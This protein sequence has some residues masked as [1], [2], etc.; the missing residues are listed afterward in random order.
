[1]TDRLTPLADAFLEV[2]DVDPDVTL[3][4]G[5]LAVF[6]GPPPT[7]EEL[8][9][10]IAGRLPLIPRYRQKL[11][12]VPLGLAAPTWV[13]D[14]DFDLT[15]HLVEATVAPPGGKAEVATLVNDLMATRM[16]RDRPLWEYTLVQGI[17][18]G[19]WGLLSKV[20]HC[21]VDGVSGTELYQL[22]LDLTPEPGP[23]VPDTWE[24]APPEPTWRFTTT[25]AR[26]MVASPLHAAAAVTRAAR[27]PVRLARTTY[28]ALTGLLPMTAALRPVHTTSLHGPV[29]PGRRWTW[30][31]VAMDDVQ[32]VRH[33]HGVSVNDVALAALSAGFRTLLDTRGEAPD[34]RALRALV[35]VSTRRPGEESI[36]DNRVTLLMPF[37]PVDVADPVER[38]GVVHER[39]AG[40]RAW[41]EPEAGEGIT[42]VAGVSPFPSVHWG[43]QIGWR[44][45]QHM[46]STVA[47]NV[48]GP[49]VPLYALGREMLEVIPYV[50]IANR[51][52][53][54]TAIFS[55]H[56]RLAFGLTGDRAT[57]L[58]LDVL[59]DGIVEGVRELVA[60]VPQTTR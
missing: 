4:I 55:Y 15:H 32:A 10:A 5:S 33:A 50:P 30:T 26:E 39:V 35:P 1:M 22:L 11:R 40:L 38:L 52:R 47:T 44:L 46:V 14:P 58:D 19:R 36:P 12:R 56:G 8:R 25:A 27:R 6:A 17:A 28:G 7:L 42:G 29:G 60:T 2:E 21:V 18:G 37:L 48:P 57:T 34:R 54:S 3:A 59:A 16:D 45:P 23:A 51:V 49:P 24:P 31:D 20:H 53:I 9:T 13:D 43:L 41:H